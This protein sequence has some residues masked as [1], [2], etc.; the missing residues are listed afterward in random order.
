MLC[1]YVPSHPAGELNEDLAAGTAKE[2]KDGKLDFA[3]LRN[4]YVTLAAEA[5]ANVK[6]LQT[7]ARH[8]TPAL[9]MNVYA[10]NRNGRL[11]ELAE[12]IGET[13]LFETKCAKSAPSKL[14][15]SPEIEPNLLERKLLAGE[16][17]SGGGGIRTPVPRCFKTSFYMLS[18]LIVFSPC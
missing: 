9:T 15:E 7:L 5:G 10:R 6:E 2:T 14:V 3:A 11:S 1:L 12:K 17:E 18:R 16:N 8:S 13:V 4:S